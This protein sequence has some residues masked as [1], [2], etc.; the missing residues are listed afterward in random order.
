MRID[1]RR[2]W[3]ALIGEDKL[4]EAEGDVVKLLGFWLHGFESTRHAAKLTI[5]MRM[6]MASLVNMVAKQPLMHV[7]ERRHLCNSVV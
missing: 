6:A 3:P 1:V 5:K 2:T 4:E 7:G